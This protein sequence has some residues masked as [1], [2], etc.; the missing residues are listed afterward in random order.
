MLLFSA[1]LF[2]GSVGLKDVLKYRF[3]LNYLWFIEIMVRSE[4]W[5]LIIVCFNKRMD[6]TTFSSALYNLVAFREI[7]AGVN[8][9]YVAIRAK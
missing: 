1:P 3:L 8:Y 6:S 4:C 5:C 7:K 9:W 2:A